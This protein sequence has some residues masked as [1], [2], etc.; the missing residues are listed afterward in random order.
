MDYILNPYF[1]VNV[2]WMI[3]VIIVA[4]II[5]KRKPI[6]KWMEDVDDA[7]AKSSDIF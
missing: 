1:L 6:E 3:T 5:T 2:L 4:G 7:A